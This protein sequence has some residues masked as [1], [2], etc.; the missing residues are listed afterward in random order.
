[1]S[2]QGASQSQVLLA[3]ARSNNL[4]LLKECL[5]STDRPDINVVDSIGNTAL[6]NAA[7]YG[8]LECLD[9]LLDQDSIDLDRRNRLEGDTPLHAA[10]RNSREDAAMSLEIGTSVG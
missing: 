6:H 2:T 10:V 4:D 7:R 5:A 9:Y 3:A 1:M 8:C